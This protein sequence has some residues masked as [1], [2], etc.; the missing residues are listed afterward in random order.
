[1]QR[2]PYR[3][4]ILNHYSSFVRANGSKLPT[5]NCKSPLFPTQQQ[6]HWDTMRC[7]KTARFL[8]SSLNVAVDS[9]AEAMNHR[10]DL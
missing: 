3:A 7:T 1:M 2:L 5:T 9:S 8:S 10:Q 4:V 6:N